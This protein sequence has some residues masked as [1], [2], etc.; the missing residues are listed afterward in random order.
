MNDE[1]AELKHQ[2]EGANSEIDKKSKLLGHV[3]SYWMF[4]ITWL[5]VTVLT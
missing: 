5:V 2:L 3:G 1:I 4:N